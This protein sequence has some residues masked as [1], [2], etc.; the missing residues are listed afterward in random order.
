MKISERY[1]CPHNKL[2]IT[3]LTLLIAFLATELMF[4]IFGLYRTFPLVDV[5]SHFLSGMTMA[6][7][8]Y[9]I[10]SL[11]KVR[12]KAA[13]TIMYTF[14][15]AIIWE[16]LETL[17]EM[18]IPNPPWLVDYWIWD[19]IFDITVTVFAGIVALDLLYILNKKK[20]I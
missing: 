9:W 13:A 10:L 6:V 4:R 8:I 11:T 20:L 18:V 7:A 5:I 14:F 1:R 12:R 19:G 3:A 2:F 16:V 17:E 15:A